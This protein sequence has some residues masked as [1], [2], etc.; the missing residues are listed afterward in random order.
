LDVF[1][2]L[3]EDG[4]ERRL[5]AQAFSRG[6]IGGYDDVLDFLVGYSIDVDVTRQPAS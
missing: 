1:A 6:E 2:K 4:L 3:F 5:E